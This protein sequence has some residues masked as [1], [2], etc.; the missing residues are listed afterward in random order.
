MVGLL[1]ADLRRTLDVIAAGLSGRA[2]AWGTGTG[3]PEHAAEEVAEAAAPKD[4]FEFLRR[5]RLVADLRSGSEWWLPGPAGALPGVVVLPVRPQL[6][7]LLAL[8][9]VA[10]NLVG[11]VDLLEARFGLG[12]TLV[13][14]RVV[15][16]GQ[17]AEGTLDLLLA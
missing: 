17:L 2:K 11:V 1:Q 9:R 10:Q 3:A 12:V 13:D 5:H 7:I 14:V 4:L 16:A 6:V 15:L 8:L